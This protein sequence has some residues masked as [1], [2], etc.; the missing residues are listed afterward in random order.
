MAKQVSHYVTRPGRHL[1]DPPITIPVAEDLG[2]IP[3]IPK[4][5]GDV[6]FFSREQPLENMALEE[7]A[8]ADWSRQQRNSHSPEALAFFEEHQERMEPIVE[9]VQQSGDL[10]PSG[11]PSGEDMTEAIRQKAREL[12]YGEV[13]FTRNNP[14]YV[15][16]SRK[17]AMRGGLPNAICLALEQDY[18]KTQS[19]PSLDAEHTHFGTYFDQGQLIVDLT[20]FIRSMGYRAQVS[21]PTWHYGPMIPMFVEAG[22]G[23]LGANG[24]LLSPHFGSRARLQII[25]TD[26]NV[27]YD[28]PIDYGIHKFCQECQVC[29]NRCPG[30]ALMPE[31]VWYRG[32]EKNKLAFKRCRPVMARYLGC[33]IC[34]KACPIQRYGMQPVMEHYVETGEIL[35]K[36][37]ESLEGYTLSDKGHFGPGELPVF[38]AKFF[39]MPQG[40]SEDWLL[41]DFRNKLM[42]VEGDSTVNRDQM[43]TEFRDNVEVSL[44][45]RSTSVDMGM[46]RGI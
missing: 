22:L 13:G 20:D 42:E 30:R 18:H 25:F 27:T 3:G 14:Q 32:V 21:G 26:A 39:D 9:W 1:G 35:G 37:T 16:Q 40:R 38:D 15:Y 12:G 19:I 28:Q 11:T 8:S 43:W 5:D 17:R 23:Q 41:I 33:G 29:V 44:K 46:D 7:S 4:R 10:E 24:Q 6:S 45:E 31:K 34:M 36:G 2:S